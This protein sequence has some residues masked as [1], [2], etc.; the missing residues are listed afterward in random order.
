MLNCDFVVLDLKLQKR[1]YV[2]FRKDIAPPPLIPLIYGLISTIS[3]IVSV[4][5]WSERPRFIPKSS[6][7]KD[8]KNGT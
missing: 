4:R 3:R 6:H 5:Q 7:T 1:Y 2:H 8:P